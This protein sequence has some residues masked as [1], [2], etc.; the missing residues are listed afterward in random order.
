MKRISLMTLVIE[1]IIV[2]QNLNGNVVL[3][4]HKILNFETSRYS[5][6]QPVGEVG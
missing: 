4:Y 2:N 5:V 1:S 6:Q 3:V